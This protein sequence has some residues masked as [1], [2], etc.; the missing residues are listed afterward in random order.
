[1]KKKERGKR[2]Q[3]VDAQTA[4]I[5]DEPLGRWMGDLATIHWR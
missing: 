1:M 5:S 3:V 4:L 2:S